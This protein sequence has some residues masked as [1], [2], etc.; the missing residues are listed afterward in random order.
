V[1]R[2]SVG[3]FGGS[4]SDYMPWPRKDEDDD[5]PATPAQIMALLTS[6]VRRKR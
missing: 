3:R 1:A 6:T 2:F 4:L 5:E